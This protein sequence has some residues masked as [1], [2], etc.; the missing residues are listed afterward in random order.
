M[1]LDINSNL[2]KWIGVGASEQYCNY[3]ILLCTYGI[4]VS[5]H[6]KECKSIA[7]EFNEFFRLDVCLKQY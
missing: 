2:W 5:V 3:L 7:K 4:Q 1:I 6:S